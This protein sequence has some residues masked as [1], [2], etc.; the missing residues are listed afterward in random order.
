MQFQ[1]S[2]AQTQH[3]LDE[4]ALAMYDPSQGATILS[5]TPRA[6]SFP[7]HSMFDITLDGPTPRA[8][9]FPSTVHDSLSNGNHGPPLTPPEPSPSTPSTSPSPFEPERPQNASQPQLQQQPGLPQFTA[10]HIARR[11]QSVQRVR[12][13]TAS[14]AAQISSFNAPDA[15]PGAPL[16]LAARRRGSSISSLALPAHSHTLN[17]SQP[18]APQPAPQAQQVPPPLPPNPHA[19]TLQLAGTERRPKRGDEDYIKRPENA[20]ILFRRECCLR[21]NE[22]EVAAAQEGD[23]VTRR[24]RQ[25]D[26]SKT[27]SQ[28][29]RSLSAEER[30]YWDDLAKQRKKEHEE[31][32]PW[33]VYQPSRSDKKKKKDE[34]TAGGK[35][36]KEKDGKKEKRDRTKS[37]SRVR[38]TGARA[39]NSS[40]C[41]TNST[42]STTSMSSS[43]S[44]VDSEDFSELDSMS[45]DGSLY[46]AYG[47]ANGACGSVPEV[48][49]ADLTDFDMSE[50]EG[51]QSQG[52]AQPLSLPLSFSMSGSGGGLAIDTRN[53]LASFSLESGPISSSYSHHGGHGHGHGHSL[54]AQISAQTVQSIVPG[55]LSFVLPQSRRSTSAPGASAQQTD[56]YPPAPPAIKLPQLL[57]TN[58]GSNNNSAGSPAMENASAAGEQQAQVNGQVAA[59]QREGE[60]NSMNTFQ[61]PSSHPQPQ[62]PMAFG[63]QG[64]VP[65]FS[66][67]SGEM[68]QNSMFHVYEEPPTARPRP[69]ALTQ[70]SIPSE[71][72][73]NSGP[74]SAPAPPTDSS[75]RLFLPDQ[76]PTSSMQPPSSQ[77]QVP[78]R[79]IPQGLPESPE[80]PMGGDWDD[81]GLPSWAMS[82]LCDVDEAALQ[83]QQQQQQQ[84]AQQQQHPQEGQE[85]QTQNMFG[86]ID[87]TMDMGLPP[88]MGFG[89]MDSMNPMGG[90]MSGMGC[91]MDAMATDNGERVDPYAMHFQYDDLLD[92]SQL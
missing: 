17:F 55:P 22:A 60:Y 2:A 12:A 53:A 56:L 49:V 87:I 45:G 32:Y 16:T 6:L 58:V 3:E 62:Q 86:E 24:Q 80:P 73:I 9:T 44:T 91:G 5:P 23:P 39:R 10:P 41:S 19:H 18:P 20:F 8:F 68:Q 72:P 33:Y 61:F 38:G 70:L 11:S 1:R 37:T 42:V 50:S 52:Q 7:T 77:L 92:P 76:F 79:A 34:S 25:A 29:W 67:A 48:E 57:E 74:L 31:R 81:F 59:Q 27:I 66:T 63:M 28:Q 43:A 90:G 75:S 64:Q 30:K 35:A 83:Q 47:Y 82:T 85:M 14:P 46:G 4:H 54:S 15:H 88:W 89:T 21:K 26:L 65:D 78:Q 51:P 71:P 13:D 36:R 84:V 40:A 69:R